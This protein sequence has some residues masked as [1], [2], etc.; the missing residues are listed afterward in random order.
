MRR[1]LAALTVI[2]L[3]SVLAVVLGGVMTLATDVP[4]IA[5]APAAAAA[6]TPT[7]LGTVRIGTAPTGVA[8]DAE[9]NRVYVAD[10]RAGTLLVVD[11]ATNTV[12]VHAAGARVPA[13]GSSVAGMSVTVCDGKTSVEYSGSPFRTG[14]DRMGPVTGRSLASASAI[15]AFDADGPGCSS[16]LTQLARTPGV[17]RARFCRLTGRPRVPRWP[18]RPGGCSGSD[19]GASRRRMTP[20]PGVTIRETIACRR[21]QPDRH[22]RCRVFN[23]KGRQ[24][25]WC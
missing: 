16:G 9:T 3:A 20:I 22:G 25:P 7:A 4:A 6:G 10:A 21:R 2:R 17:A 18:A 19:A 23:W 11:G 13:L 12:S 5:I 15:R 14:R 24:P 8:A 1:M